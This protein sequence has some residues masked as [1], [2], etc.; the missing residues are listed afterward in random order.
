M[1]LTTKSMKLETRSSLKIA[2]N[3]KIRSATKVKGAITGAIV[4]VLLSASL[5]S[6]ASFAQN[7][8]R[9]DQVRIPVGSQA[10]SNITIPERGLTKSQV[11]AQFGEPSRR[12]RTV[13]NPPIS[14][15]YY[16]QFTVYFE[17]SHVVHAVRKVK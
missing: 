15:W 12:S 5:I 17:Y 4:S 16:P 10:N 14:Q 8:S 2:S 3:E 13:G 9:G 7:N 6:N 1:K 11:S